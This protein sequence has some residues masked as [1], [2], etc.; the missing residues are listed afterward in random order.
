M[1]LMN[2]V[3]RAD[4]R[5]RQNTGCALLELV[6]GILQ[7]NDTRAAASDQVCGSVANSARFSCNR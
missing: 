3:I 5:A 4:G 1:M 7:Q 2:R 6:L